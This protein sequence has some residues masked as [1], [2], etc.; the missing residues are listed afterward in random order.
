MLQIFLWTK[1]ITDC[2]MVT[3]GGAIAFNDA[4]GH[5]DGIH[6]TYSHHEQASAI[7]AE[8]YARIDNRIAVTLC[9]YRTGR[10]ECDH[11]CSRRM[12]GFGSDAGDL[13][14]GTL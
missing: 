9:N 13:R 1:G 4:I 8:A 2:F 5:K 12:V 11:R 10:D 14:A 6:C 3:G 7:A